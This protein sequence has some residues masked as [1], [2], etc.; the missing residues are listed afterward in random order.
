MEFIRVKVVDPTPI[1]LKQQEVISRIGQ[2]KPDHML[3][4]LIASLLSNGS[5]SFPDA[6]RRLD[7][8]NNHVDEEAFSAARNE[9]LRLEGTEVV[10]LPGIR[11][12]ISSFTGNLNFRRLRVFSR[13]NG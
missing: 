5:V 8:S 3:F 11:E 4:N 7:S 1:V 13:A 6:R 9:V 12:S 2:G 10:Y